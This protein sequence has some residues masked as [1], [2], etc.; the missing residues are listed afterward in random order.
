[1]ISP[2]MTIF[3]KKYII[4]LNIFKRLTSKSGLFVNFYILKVMHLYVY[5]KKRNVNYDFKNYFVIIYAVKKSIK[6][7]IFEIK[8]VDLD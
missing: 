2:T 6:H 7:T 3:T 5:Y 4:S 1:M 8:I